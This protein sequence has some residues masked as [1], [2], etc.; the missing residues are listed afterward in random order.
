MMHHN[1]RK[2]HELEMREMGMVESVST[3]GLYRGDE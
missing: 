1:I 3:F 2:K